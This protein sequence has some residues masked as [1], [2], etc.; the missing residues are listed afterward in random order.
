MRRRGGGKC[1]CPRWSAEA[2]PPEQGLC[3]PGQP[4]AGRWWSQDSCWASALSPRPAPLGVDS[5][6]CRLRLVWTER[7]AAGT[8][9][10]LAC[11]GGSLRLSGSREGSPVASGLCTCAPRTAAAWLATWTCARVTTCAVFATKCLSWAEM[12]NVVGG[13]GELRGRPHVCLSPHPWVLCSRRAE[14]MCVWSQGGVQ[15][16]CFRVDSSGGS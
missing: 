16:L 7:P 3:T 10:E 8:G 9:R 1:P 4:S 14:W 11:G 6:W 2:T 12:P 13:L 5:A 15:A